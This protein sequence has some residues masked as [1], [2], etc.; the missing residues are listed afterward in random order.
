MAI[1]DLMLHHMNHSS[2]F[3]SVRYTD[4]MLVKIRAKDWFSLSDTLKDSGRILYPG[5]ESGIVYCIFVVKLM[6][7]G[8]D[9]VPE[10]EVH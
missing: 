9:I 6:C 7:K 10:R 8:L 2:G 5:R 3:Y 1:S 4:F